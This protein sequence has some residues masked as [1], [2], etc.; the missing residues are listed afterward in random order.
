MK[1]KLITFE[2]IEGSG[3]TTQLKLISEKLTSEGFKLITTKEPGGSPPGDRIRD[4]LLDPDIT[5]LD[6]KTELF[7]FLADRVEHIRS[8][9]LPALS[10]GA[11]VLSDRFNDSTIAYQGYARGLGIEFV[12][13]M[14]GM[15]DLALTPDLTLLFDIPPETA[16]PRVNPGAISRFEEEPLAFHKRVREGYLELARRYPERIKIISGELPKDKVAKQVEEEVRKI[17]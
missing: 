1:G 14:L 3:K 12:T 4:I 7:L 10:K 16:L 8:L 11:I 15:F 17:I 9:I 6:P 2:G 13:N 5:S